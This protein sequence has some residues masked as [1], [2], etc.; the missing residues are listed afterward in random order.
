[1]WDWLAAF[2][3]LA[4]DVAGEVVAAVEAAR[5]VVG[6]DDA[7]ATEASV[8]P[9]GGEVWQGDA[10]DDRTG[11]NEGSE[12][13]LVGHVLGAQER[14]G[15]L[16]DDLETGIHPPKRFKIP[17]VKDKRLR[18]L[19]GSAIILVL[20]LGMA[21][22]WSTVF[23]KS[24]QVHNE[25]ASPIATQAISGAINLL[26]P[27]NG[28]HVLVASSDDWAGTING[29]EGGTQISYGLGTSAVFAFKDERPATFDMF[30]MLIPGTQNNNVKEFELLQGNES[31]TGLFQSIGKFQTQNVKLFEKPYQE[32]KF[33]PVTAKYLKVKILSTYDSPHPWVF[34][35]QLFGVLR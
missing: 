16:V 2:G 30:T 12:A 21:F 10:S 26:A 19:A 23:Q 8:E 17:R 22:V 32:F 18:W 20:L 33:S 6:Q 1:M 9:S 7:A 31:P 24:S 25:T 29:N 15:E 13:G 14:V 35:F 5:A 4:A 11:G 34:Q 3:A 27:E 28:G